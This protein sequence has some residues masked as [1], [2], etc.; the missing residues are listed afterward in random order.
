M[1]HATQKRHHTQSS[2]MLATTV[3]WSSFPFN[4][5]L[6]FSQQKHTIIDIVYTYT[7]SFWVEPLHKLYNYKTLK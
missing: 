7:K 4:T 3:N 2:C 6:S 5:R 1:L